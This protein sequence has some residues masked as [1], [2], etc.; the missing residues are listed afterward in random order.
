MSESEHCFS[1]EENENGPEYGKAEYWDHRYNENSDPFE[2]YLGWDRIRE[3]LSS[4]VGNNMNSL[5]IG[6]GNS[7]MSY[8]M[9]KDGFVNVVSIDISQILIDQM[10]YRYI[11]ESKL[12]WFQMDCTDLKFPD[13]SFDTVFDKGTFDAISCGSNSHSIIEK[14][15]KE[16][17]RVLK[18]GGRF[19]EITYARPS[20]RFPAMRSSNLTWH[21]Y[22][23]EIV[24][25]IGRSC[26]YFYIFEKI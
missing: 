6:C 24:G 4:Y 11:K 1:D 9:L 16:I 3:V 19:F 26:H 20:H 12:Q 25:M 15:M 8:D 23:P 2:W 22:P 18:P 14:T 21:V 7:P 10:K 13:S 5:V 17:H